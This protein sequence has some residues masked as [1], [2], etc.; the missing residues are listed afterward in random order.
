[1]NY[2]L[3]ADLGESDLY[4]QG[5]R[6]AVLRLQKTEGHTNVDGITGPGTRAL[7]VRKLTWKAGERVFHVMHSPGGEP[8]PR[9][10]VSYASEDRPAAEEVVDFL[11]REGVELWVD[12]RN[13]QPGQKWAM[14]IESAIPASRYFLALISRHTLSKKGYVQKEVK[15]AWSVADHYPDSQVFVI[16]ARLE[17]CEVN[18]TRFAQLQRVDLFPERGK[19]LKRLVD[20]L[21][22]D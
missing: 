2:I 8:F 5:V 18:D 3:G 1:L 19:G 9:V 11:T 13:L 16:P 6:E 21:A 10:F 15:T 14:A 20:F 12:F 7:L 4:D 22:T 17:A